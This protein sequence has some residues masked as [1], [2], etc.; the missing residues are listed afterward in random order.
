MATRLILLGTKGGPRPTPQYR[1]QPAQVIV[2]DGVPYVVD[3]GSGV[4]DRLVLAG[5]ALPALRHVFITHHHSDHVLDY[6]N[7]LLLAWAAG[8]RS[9]V[10]TWG[11]PPLAGMTRLA[12]ALN[13]VDIDTRIVEEGRP[14]P[15]PLVIAHDIAGAG[16]VM[17]D[18]RVRVTAA[19]VP[20][21]PI[22]PA[23]AYRFDTAD[24]SIVISGDTAYAPALAEFARGAD[25]LVHEAIYLPAVERL[26]ARN[27]NAA[28]LREHLLSTHTTPEDAGRI[29][30]AAGVGMLV[31]SHLVP[32][33]DPAVT[34]DLWFAAARQTYAGP[35]VVAKDLM[36]L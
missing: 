24:R 11:P 4:A 7:L 29:A 3:C 34:D 35:I 21:G 22:K 17:A 23:F 12:F 16:P 5:I 27:P 33:D 2:V 28:T 20:H 19:L 8:L 14:D 30:S 1:G 15:R 32:G 31:L 10:D 18:E 36:E 9:R 26:L 25:V 13:Q 6:G